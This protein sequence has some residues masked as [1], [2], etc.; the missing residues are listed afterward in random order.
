MWTHRHTQ[1]PVGWCLKCRH[2]CFPSGRVP[3]RPATWLTAWT[4]PE[5]N[6]WTASNSLEER[7][8]QGGRK[9]V[10]TVAQTDA[11]RCVFKPA[12]QNFCLPHVAVRFP[13]YELCH[14]CCRLPLHNG[15]SPLQF[16]NWGQNPCYC[17]V[18]A[19]LSPHTNTNAIPLHILSNLVYISLW[20]A[21]CLLCLPTGNNKNKKEFMYE[22]WW[23]GCVC[24][25][26]IQL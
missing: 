5:S 21:S 10:N 15:C 1:L 18:S 17:C 12:G 20:S 16:Y 13:C 25:V 3:W 23:D 2:S 24:L 9:V 19:E 4:E 7:D 8:R 26:A 11:A 22:H 6:S 14:S